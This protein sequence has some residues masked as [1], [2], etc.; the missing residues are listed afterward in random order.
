VDHASGGALFDRIHLRPLIGR[1]A[2]GAASPTGRYIPAVSVALLARTVTFRAAHRYFRPDWSAEQNRGAFGECTTAPGH[3]HVYRCRVIVSGP[4]SPDTGMVMDLAALDRLLEE[5]IIL[6]FDGRHINQ[7]VPEFAFG[8]QIPTGEALA[9]FVWGR[10]VPRLPQT[11][12]LQAVR[13]QEDPHL[14]AEYHG[15]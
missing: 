11:V 14:Y 4:I 6:R 2:A 9:A 10:L 12:R 5:E 3:E 13:V 7:S 15:A 8:K 1:T